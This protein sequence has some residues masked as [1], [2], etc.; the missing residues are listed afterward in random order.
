MKF[1]SIWLEA[2]KPKLNAEGTRP[3]EIEAC[4]ATHCQG[5]SLVVVIKEQR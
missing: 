1:R 2:Q 3:R 4:S 5:N